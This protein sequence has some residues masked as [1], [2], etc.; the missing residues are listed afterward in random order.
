MTELSIHAKK[1]LATINDGSVWI[2]PYDPHMSARRKAAIEELLKEGLI[3]QA[4]RVETVV[5]C[6]VPAGT[7]GL[8]REEYPDIVDILF[9][10]DRYDA[11][12]SGLSKYVLAERAALAQDRAEGTHANILSRLNFPYTV[13]EVEVRALQES[14]ARWSRI[15]QRHLFA[16]IDKKEK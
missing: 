7:R 6:Y 9:L 15:A 4:G 1:L 13:S 5:A 2:K 8:R 3:G 14:R 12:V 11:D 16:L 10:E